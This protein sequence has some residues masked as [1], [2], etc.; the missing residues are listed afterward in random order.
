MMTAEAG[1]PSQ[2]PGISLQ[3]RGNDLPVLHELCHALTA[4]HLEGTETVIDIKSLPFG[5][6]DE[7]RLGKALGTGEVEAVLHALGESRITETAFPGIW[8]IEHRN[9]QGE[10]IAKSIEVTRIPGILKS[11]QADIAAARRRLESLVQLTD[12]VD[13]STPIDN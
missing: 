10:V 3:D 7:H 9:E 11:Q 12:Q 13:E 6:S 4:L 2:H 5:E 1:N 8:W